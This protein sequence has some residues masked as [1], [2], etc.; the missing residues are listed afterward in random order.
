M[1]QYLMES[2]PGPRAQINGRQRDYFA[3]C[4]YFGLSGHPELM[5]VA[6]EALQRYGLSTGTS[7]G[8]FGDSPIYRDLERAS[9]RYFDAE[10]IT[11]YVS[12]YFGSAILLQGL[13]DTYDQVFVDEISHFSVRDGIRMADVPCAT[14]RHCDPDD[15][16]AQLRAGLK[17]GARP[18]VITDGLFPVSGDIPPLPA[19]LRALAPYEN[20]SLIV[21]DAHASGVL[22]PL[23]RGSLDHFG[24]AAPR[25]Y[26]AHTLSKAFAGHGGLI[27]GSAELK[28]RL[29]AGAKIMV[30][31]SETPLPAAAV[32]AR[33]LDLVWED[34]SIRRRLW[35]N[36][37]HAR[38]GLRALG[39]P[40]ADTPAP[41]ICLGARPG[42]DLARV[43]Q[44]LFARDICVLHA[45]S[46]SST[47][48]GGALRIAIFSTHTAEQIDRLI[49][50]IGRLIA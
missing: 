26:A 30:G 22:G 7:R 3:G 35:Q 24:I 12:A 18:L 36:V 27:A 37:A 16:A 4:S 19:Y 29:A 48:A 13:R 41:I 17:P 6:Q 31:A 8:G 20:A 38:A 2:P 21:D 40:L 32:A 10:D 45:T 11:Y 28:A 49:A 34:P 42:L 43:Q 33:S 15:L 46:Y 5:R 1:G 23:G 9:R 50:E 39:W 47:P 14:F 25:C 44:A